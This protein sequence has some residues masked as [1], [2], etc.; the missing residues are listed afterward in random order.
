MPW[1][2][3]FPAKPPGAPS[4][5]AA[6]PPPAL[7]RWLRA[8]P[9]CEQRESAPKNNTVGP[10][11][12][13]ASS[14]LRLFL[15]QRMQQR[16]VRLLGTS[17]SSRSSPGEE[18]PPDPDP[19][20]APCSWTGSQQGSSAHALHQL[21]PA[22]EVLGTSEVAAEGTTRFC[23]WRSKRGAHRA[24]ASRAVVP[25]LKFSQ[26]LRNVHKHQKAR[27]SF[28]LHSS[29]VNSCSHPCLARVCYLGWVEQ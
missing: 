6:E 5:P 9:K 1:H 24:N 2:R 11:A 7:S 26:S 14:R 15:T 10:S 16:G 18:T 22:R 20:F 21:L 17:S 28:Q 23:S 29:V 25:N 8:A 27:R 4:P 19:G 3:A 13:R 12:T